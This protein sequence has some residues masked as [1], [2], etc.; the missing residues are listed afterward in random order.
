MAL[1]QLSAI[2]QLQKS[3]TRQKQAVSSHCFNWP[4]DQAIAPDLFIRISKAELQ[5]ANL[6]SQLALLYQACLALAQDRV[7][8]EPWSFEEEPP[9]DPLAGIRFVFHAQTEC[10]LPPTI[11]QYKELH[12]LAMTYSQFQKARRQLVQGVTSSYPELTDRGELKLIPKRSLTLAAW[13]QKEYQQEIADIDV[14]YCL[15]GY[16]Q[17]YQ[18]SMTLLQANT[19]GQRTALSILQLIKLH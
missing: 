11:E 14:D 18:Q 13:A 2:K 4:S 5:V 10:D 17:F 19:D 1:L 15:G 9:I 16:N 7:I 12:E 8:D 6:V 3:I